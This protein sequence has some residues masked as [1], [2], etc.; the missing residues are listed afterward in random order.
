MGKLTLRQ[1]KRRQR[2][3]NK[4]RT[5]KKQL[6]GYTY[7]KTPK[8]R[9]NRQNGGYGQYQNN[10]PNGPT[11]AV[12]GLQTPGWSNALASPPPHTMLSRL[13]NGVDNY[14]HFKGFGFPSR[15]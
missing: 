1:R 12:G 6:G 8:N 7:K 11:M 15:N 9:K 2:Q 13:V 4:K 10:V 5:T 3:K 14:N